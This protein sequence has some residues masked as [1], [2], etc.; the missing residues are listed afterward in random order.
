MV[1]NPDWQ[2]AGRWVER[3]LRLAHR[4]QRNANVLL[5]YSSREIRE[6]LR[7][8][9]IV[10]WWTLTDCFW[11]FLLYCCVTKLTMKVLL[12]GLFNFLIDRIKNIANNMGNSSTSF[13]HSAI[14]CTSMLEFKVF[15]LSHTVLSL[16]SGLRQAV[17]YTTIQ[18]GLSHSHAWK[19]LRAPHCRGKKFYIAVS[20]SQYML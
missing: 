10:W 2:G 20:L 12:S 19:P 16:V 6:K 17:C 3:K 7:K 8:L 13:K 4:C 14:S 9:R 11:V 15:V 18:K 1:P 5:Y